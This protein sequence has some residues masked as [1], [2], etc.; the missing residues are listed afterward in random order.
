MQVD[1]LRAAG[2][3]RMRWK[4]GK[5]ETVEIAIHPEA[6]GTDDFTWRISTATVA[7]DGPFSVFP[8]IDRN[9]SI[10]TGKGMVLDVA[11]SETRLDAS[12][13]PYAFPGDQPTK[14][15][16]I[17]GKVTDLNVMTRRGAASAQ[18][19]RHAVDGP[20]DLPL[21]TGRALVLVAHGRASWG[22]ETLGPGDCLDIAG[23]T[24]LLKL[25]GQ[26]VLYRVLLDLP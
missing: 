5:G 21:Q 8:G 20:L 15:R 24:G 2:H 14:A 26:A 12:S 6:A 16:L 18:V 1:I 4:N 17:D 11:G 25:S 7:E 13:P 10:L 22:T 23:G 3:R 9:L 19:T